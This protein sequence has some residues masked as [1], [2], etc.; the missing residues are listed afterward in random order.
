M[1]ELQVV[2]QSP[3]QPKQLR[4]RKLLGVFSRESRSNSEEEE[5]RLR[6]AYLGE[7]SKHLR[8]MPLCELESIGECIEVIE[9]N[10]GTTTP[11]ENLILDLLLDHALVGLEPQKAA[12]RVEEFRE[13]FDDAIEAARRLMS[14]YPKEF[15]I[16]DHAAGAR[17]DSGP[18]EV[19]DGIPVVM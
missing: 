9:N 15:A 5:T 10:L 12:E 3:S 13:N 1:P 18:K 19:K 17:D 11:A 14:R 2:P 6:K 4:Y 7:I 8:R 16:Q